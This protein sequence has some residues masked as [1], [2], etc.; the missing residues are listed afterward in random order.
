MG[1]WAFELYPKSKI[2]VNLRFEQH[3][4][5]SSFLMPSYEWI[6]DQRFFIILKI[7]LSA[8]GVLF[9]S[10]FPH[11]AQVVIVTHSCGDR[12]GISYLT[13]FLKVRKNLWARLV[14]NICTALLGNIFSLKIE[15]IQRKAVHCWHL[16]VNS[17]L[18]VLCI[19]FWFGAQAEFV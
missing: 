8:P 15:K 1:T 3:P 13:N 19:V 14:D 4:W 2:W 11:T 10:R 5:Y 18:Q 6:K 16:L 12:I 7:K 17:T 9:H